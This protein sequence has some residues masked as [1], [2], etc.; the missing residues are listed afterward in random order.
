MRLR[1]SHLT[2]GA[3]ARL[4]AGHGASLY[5]GFDPPLD[6]SELAPPSGQ[7]EGVLARLSLVNP[8][9]ALTSRNY[10]LRAYPKKGS[11]PLNFWGSDPFFG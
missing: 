5:R 3:P 11:D 1:P 8:P 4:G 7:L 6:T 9:E 10:A 2:C